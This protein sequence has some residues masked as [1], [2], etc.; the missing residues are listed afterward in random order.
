MKI[1][2]IKT[3]KDIM[4]RKIFILIISFLLLFNLS[5]ASEIGEEIYID[6]GGWCPNIPIIFTLYDLDEWNIREEI[7]KDK[8]INFTSF[9]DSKITIHSGPFE[10][11]SELYTSKTNENSFSYTF[12]SEGM[13]LIRVETEKIG[14]K[15][16]N[17]VVEV[18]TCRHPSTQRQAENKTVIFNEH[19]L[20]IKLTESKILEDEVKIIQK[21][22]LESFP[23]IENIN[24]ILE[25]QSEELKDFS[26][27][28]IEL[29]NYEN[30]EKILFLNLDENSWENISF[31]TQGN[32]V[33]F[34]MQEFG[35]LAIINK[36]IEETEVIQ[37]ELIEEEKEELNQEII[38]NNNESEDNNNLYY[39]IGGILIF[40]LFTFYLINKTN[41]EKEL[42][43]S[44]KEQEI[45][46]S[47]NQ[48]YERTK[49]YVKQYKENY[50]GLQIKTALKQANIHD[51]IIDKVF[52]EEGV[53]F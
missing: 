12:N 1:Y 23:Q 7:S 19:N 35:I 32:N 6:V 11:M 44:T 37:E 31:Q 40:G 3:K 16:T 17:K 29:S 25:I 51:D 42:Y 22:N 43:H 24:K 4:F 2:I 21:N 30:I 10:S 8:D 15:N 18:V 33:V 26:K 20:K 28:E 39:I 45:L 50:S 53:K 34:E 9:K 5:F 48:E 41:K 46:T 27:L 49:E 38:I 47:Y 13:Y 52:L 36:E 14:Y